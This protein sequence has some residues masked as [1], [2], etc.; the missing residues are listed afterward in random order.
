MERGTM[1]ADGR[2]R[3][4]CGK[5]DGGA[6]QGGRRRTER[7]AGGGGWGGPEPGGAVRGEVGEWATCRRKQE[8]PSANSIT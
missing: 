1:A 5:R 7:R 3:C 8:L 6:R 4:G 2:T